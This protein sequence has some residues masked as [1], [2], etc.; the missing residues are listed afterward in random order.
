MIQQDS[1]QSAFGL[2]ANVAAGLASFFGVVG[3]IVILLGKPVQQWVRFVAVQSIVLWC[4]WIAFLIA[5]NIVLG[6]VGMIP[7]LRLVL[8]PIVLLSKQLALGIVIFVAWLMTTIKAFSGQALRLPVVA[9]LAEHVVALSRQPAGRWS[10][11]LGRRLPVT[12]TIMPQVPRL[13]PV[14]VAHANL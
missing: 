12:R 6:I 14:S 4:A 9:A 11:I 7:G 8:I 10:A 1:S 2:A 5:I 3:G 13:T